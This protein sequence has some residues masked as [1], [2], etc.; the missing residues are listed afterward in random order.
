MKLIKN[1]KCDSSTPSDEEIK[2]GLDI[3]STEHCIVRL[4]W[5]FPYSG[6]YHMDI[7]EGM[8]FEECKEKLPKRYPV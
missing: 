1:Y 5:F 4:N 3:A 7:T 6:H 2:E 8:T